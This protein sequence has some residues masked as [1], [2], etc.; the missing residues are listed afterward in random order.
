MN[1]AKNIYFLSDF[2]LGAPDNA[3]SLI[4]EK[5]IISF[6]EDIKK[7]A[8]AIFILGDLFDFWFEY[9]YVVPKGYVRILGK[10]A[11]ITDSGIPIKFF[12]GN[13]DMWMKDYFQNEMNIS[14]YHEPASFEFNGKMFLIG[15]GDGLGPGDKGYKL[16]KK[17][18]RNKMA[19]ALFGIIPPAIG[20][21]LANYFSKKSRAQTGINNEIF[22]GEDNEWLVQ[23]C[24]ERLKSS[25]FD[26]FI[27]GHRHLPLNIQLTET[28][29][30]VNLGDWIQY[31][32]YAV[33]DGNSL[34]LDYYK[35]Q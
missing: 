25:Y 18:F 5:K 23:Y 16:L 31:N 9:K 19:Q 29:S 4:R 20:I 32:S 35:K 2:H 14:V 15:H 10:L 30:Y 24:K 22:T 1:T 3:S 7:D 17:I 28:S 21:G 27:F 33:F 13:H 8:S 12:T 11:E 26:Y 6:L 34:T